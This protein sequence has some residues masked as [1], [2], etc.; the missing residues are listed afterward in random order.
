[1]ESKK[2]KPSMRILKPFGPS[3]LQMTIPDETLKKLNQYVDEIVN[4]K[5][6]SKQLDHGSDLAGNV[7]QEFFL[8]TEFMKNIK[9]AEFLASACTEWVKHEQNK[10]LNKFQITKS[11][12]VRQFKHEY[13]PIHWHS[14]H[15]SGVGYL[16]VPNT[17]GNTYQENKTNNNGKLVLVHGS[18]NLFSQSTF[19]IKP[20]VGDFYLFPSYLMHTVYPFYD[21]DEERRSISFNA[22]LDENASSY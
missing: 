6:K 16:K 3:V 7:N 8:E 2:N 11:W 13:N 9:W 1:M 22:R 10:Q 17:F 12:I 18:R 19:I 5:D 21:T 14:G 15:I 20:K 4:D